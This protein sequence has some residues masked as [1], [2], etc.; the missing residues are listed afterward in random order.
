MSN[1]ARVVTWPSVR[2]RPSPAAAPP[3]YLCQPPAC[4]HAVPLELAGG[5][6][7]CLPFSL[8]AAVEHASDR[9]REMMGGAGGG[10]TAA[11]TPSLLSVVNVEAFLWRFRP[12]KNE[13]FLFL[14]HPVFIPSVSQPVEGGLLLR[15]WHGIVVVQPAG[16]RGGRGKTSAAAAS[17][18][19]RSPA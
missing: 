3:R 19:I 6:D 12:L 7:C 1:Q 10:L 15:G 14:S 2:V 5:G 16:E 9:S 11:E 17:S 8:H 18:A 13:V 4:L